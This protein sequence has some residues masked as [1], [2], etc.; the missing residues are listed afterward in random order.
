MTRRAG[1]LILLDMPKEPRP[2]PQLTQRAKEEAALR[3]E[4]L[5]DALR[6]NLKKRKQQARAREET[7]KS[8]EER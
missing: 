1:L 4:R 6:D 7:Q 2:H 3:R 8:G 5:A